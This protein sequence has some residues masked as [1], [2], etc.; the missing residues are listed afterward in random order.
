MAVFISISHKSTK[1]I[2]NITKNILLKNID[3]NLY[4]IVQI[5]TTETIKLNNFY[6]KIFISITFED[7]DATKCDNCKLT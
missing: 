4:K 6:V 1:I 2:N 5:Y 3:L 7:K